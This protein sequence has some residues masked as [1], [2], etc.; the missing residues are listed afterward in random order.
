MRGTVLIDTPTA[1][2]LGFRV[3]TNFEKKG[4]RLGNTSSERDQRQSRVLASSGTDYVF[5]GSGQ[6]PKPKV[7]NLTSQSREL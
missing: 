4:S 1:H 3:C 5:S 6:S 7:Q 2:S